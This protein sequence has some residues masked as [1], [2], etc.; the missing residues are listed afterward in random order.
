MVKDGRL[1]VE[2]R[3]PFGLVACSSDDGSYDGLNDIVEEM[4]LEEGCLSDICY[5]VVGHLPP[6][7]EENTGYVVVKV[8]AEVDLT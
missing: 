8:D 4:I 7:G 3:L 2:V 6:D 5:E 1:T